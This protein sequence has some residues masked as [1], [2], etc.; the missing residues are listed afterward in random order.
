M[1][2]LFLNIIIL[3]IIN[4]NRFLG[5]KVVLCHLEEIIYN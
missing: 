3:E 4:Y 1:L 5:L 2:F